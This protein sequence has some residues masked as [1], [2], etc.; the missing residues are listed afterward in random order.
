[1]ERK[2]N[3]MRLPLILGSNQT[4]VLNQSNGVNNISLDY[5]IWR[6][7]HNCSVWDNNG[8]LIGSGSVD[9]NSC[10]IGESIYGGTWA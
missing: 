7:G 6:D 3:N 4:S 1:M 9:G 10:R 2:K 8:H 5:V